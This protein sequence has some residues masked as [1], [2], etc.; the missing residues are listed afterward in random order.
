[1]EVKGA[2]LKLKYKGVEQWIREIDVDE[3]EK[4]DSEFS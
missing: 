2:E 3:K 4:N 1:M